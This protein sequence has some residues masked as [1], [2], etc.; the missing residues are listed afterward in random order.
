MPEWKPVVNPKVAKIFEG[1][2]YVEDRDFYVSPYLPDDCIV[3]INEDTTGPL[4]PKDD[5]A[6]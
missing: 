1:L 4:R 3:E 5:D 2:G 6:S